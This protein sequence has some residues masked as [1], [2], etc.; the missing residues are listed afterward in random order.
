M[1]PSRRRFIRI[2]PLAGAAW[3]VAAPAHA[4]PAVDEADAQAKT[5][6][7]VNDASKVDKARFKQFAAG[8]RCGGCGLYQGAAGSAAGP[9]PIF[10]GKEV[11][12]AGWCS[13]YA[14]KA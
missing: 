14:K 12:A 10:P 13:A 11:K 9:C 3:L 6:G 1:I 7:Y 2:V 5:L 8:Q 4:A